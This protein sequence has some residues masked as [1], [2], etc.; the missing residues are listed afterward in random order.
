MTEPPVTPRPAATLILVRD[1]SS[2]IEV[3]MLQRTH[4]AAFGPGKYV[5]PGGAVDSGDSDG[6]FEAHCA[7][8]DDGGAS[9]VLGVKEGGLAY[10]VAAIRECFEEAGILLAYDKS[11][12]FLEAEESSGFD[13]MSSLRQELATTDMSFGDFC[14]SHELRLAFDKLV[15][16]SHWITPVGLPRRFDTRFFV[17][18]APDKQVA[19]HDNSETIGNAWI[20]PSEALER[21]RA[22][23]IDMMFATVKSLEMLAR[24]QETDALINHVR[25]LDPVPAFLPRAAAGRNGR[26]VLI[27]G[28][29]AYAEVGKLDPAGKG[30]TSCDI[31]PGVATH[32]SSRVRRI[33]APNPSFMTGP[34][35]NTYLVGTGDALAVIDP[36]PADE[37]HIE[38]LLEHANGRIR[39][40]LTTHTHMDHSP[41]A[42]LLKARTGAELLGMPPPDS[43]R[44]DQSFQPDIVLKDN[45]RVNV[46]DCVLRAIH[47]PGHASNHLCYLLEEERL[48]FT[49]DHVMQG[50][51]VVINPPGGDMSAYLASLH[52]LKTLDVDYFAPGHGFL[53]ANPHDVLERLLAHRLK[54]EQKVLSALRSLGSATIAELLPVAYGDVPIQRH[55]M[56]SRSLLAHLEKSRT[57]GRATELDGRWTITESPV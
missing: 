53:M 3:F 43:D 25:G 48:L 51:T 26:R 17:S 21:H 20:R 32:L 44:Q 35:T 33:A 4:G 12:R 11:G 42:S 24:F 27:Q 46:G 34:G 54:R 10:S 19:S 38:R 29:H 52:K 57:D 14:R 28:D 41:A 31:L 49:G 13:E 18:V 6:S 45:Q 15:Y 22:G 40:I 23:E 2:G 56:A 50:S 55:Q 7:G 9:R 5:F 47:T 16:V 8:Y 39:W 1:T 30:T 37:E 36:G